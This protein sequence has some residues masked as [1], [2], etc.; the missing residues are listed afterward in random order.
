M[1]KIKDWERWQS[2]RSDRCQPPWIKLH[3]CLMR[4]PEWVALTDAERGQLVAMWL[5]AADKKG[6]LPDAKTIK[7]MCYMS[8]NL[9]INKFIDLGFLVVNMTPNGS[10]DDVN[11]PSQTRLD[12][13]RLDKTREDIVLADSNLSFIESLKKNPAY[14]DIDIDRELSK[15]DAWLLTPKG[16]GRKKNHRFVLNWLNKIDVSIQSTTESEFDK[17]VREHR[18]SISKNA[19][20]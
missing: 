11:M 8:N 9:N 15:M 6:E 13:T 17:K 14:K 10:Q 7:K 12:K 19:K 2:Y 5:L 3:R 16:K 18:E 20:K 1:Y 4:N